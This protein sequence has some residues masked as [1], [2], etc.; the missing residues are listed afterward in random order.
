[1]GHTEIM[2]EIVFI[3]KQDLGIFPRVANFY[4]E[5][6]GQVEMSRD[7]Q[8]VAVSRCL[9]KRGN[10]YLIITEHSLQHSWIN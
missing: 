10:I 7:H 4:P 9:Y 3:Q 2:W 1:M 5:K 8:V 6:R